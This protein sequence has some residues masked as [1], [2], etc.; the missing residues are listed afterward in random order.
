[1][2]YYHVANRIVTSVLLLS[3]GDL[4]GSRG[5]FFSTETQEDGL[6]WDP[7]CSLVLLPTVQGLPVQE[8]H[9]QNALPMWFP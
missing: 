8:P 2:T 6:F 1:M 7:P 5:T 9:F 4:N 3:L